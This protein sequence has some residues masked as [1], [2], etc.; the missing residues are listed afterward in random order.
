MF[1]ARRA[2][3]IAPCLNIASDIRLLHV[4]SVATQRLHLT[5]SSYRLS[6]DA[7]H[8]IFIA[9]VLLCASIFCW[10]VVKN[11]KARL[12]SLFRKAFRRGFCCQTFSIDELILAVDK[13]LLCQM[14]NM[15]YWLHPLLPK[16]RNSK[17]NTCNSHE[18][19]RRQLTYYLL[20]YMHWSSEKERCIQRIGVCDWW[21]RL[22]HWI[23]H[24]HT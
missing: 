21:T 14:S 22:I 19:N 8:I 11:D 12:D 17:I 24:K 2:F 20:T 18:F 5:C 23:Q 3:I 9:I 7:L 4:L 10:T 6:R 15:K 1:H 16:H 13:K